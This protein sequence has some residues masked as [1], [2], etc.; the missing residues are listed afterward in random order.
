MIYLIVGRTGAGKDYIAGKLQEKGLKVVKSYATRPKRYDTE[1]SHIF[2]TKEEA[3]AITDKIATTEINGYEYF[4]TATQV[5]ESDIYIIDPA[6]LYELTENMPDETFHVLYVHADTMD[7]K[8]HAVARAE[9]KIKEETVFD[10]RS[11]SENEQFTEF[12]DKLSKIGTE[13]PFRKNITWINQF[14][15]T[16]DTEHTEQLIDYLVADKE[17]HEKMSNIVTECAKLSITERDEDTGKIKVLGKDDSVKLATD[18]QF[19]DIISSS[20]NSFRDMMLLYILK[21]KRFAD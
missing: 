6:G 8:I 21:S 10:K 1:D 9:D 12:E 4:A 3:N 17:I 18:E 5:R 20:P 16:Y 19:A 2:V 7:R 15:N 11:E 14:E 13:F